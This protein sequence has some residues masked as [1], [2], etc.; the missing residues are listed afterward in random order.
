MQEDVSQSI[1]VSIVV[2]LA[3][4]LLASVL[5]VTVPSIKFLTDQV[6]GYTKVVD[7][8]Y[9]QLQQATGKEYDSGRVY[10]YIMESE[11]K[12]GL[13]AVREKPVSEPNNYKVILCRERTAVT[14]ALQPHITGWDFSDLTK[15]YNE[16]SVYF[17]HDAITKDFRLTVNTFPDGALEIICDITDEYY[18]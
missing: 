11:D 6:N 1:Q 13:I 17:G 5:V 3:A 10:R 9:R 2:L 18:E 15:G 14:P 16:Y 4:T 12:I 7:M 8:S